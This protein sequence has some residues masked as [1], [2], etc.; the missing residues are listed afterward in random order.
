M[1]KQLAKKILVGILIV[2][3]IILGYETLQLKLENNTLKRAR[4]SSEL[5]SPIV[6]WMDVDEFLAYQKTSSVTFNDLKPLINATITQGTKGK[7]GVY[8]EDL[9]S[10]AWMGINEKEKFI[11]ASLLKVPLMIAILKKVEEGR[12]SLDDELTLQEEDRDMRSGILGMNEPGYK[13]N[14][15]ELLGILTKH[16][17]NTAF[18]MLLKNIS[19]EEYLSARL[20]TGIPLPPADGSETRLSPKEYSNILRSL[21]ISSYLSRPFSELAL[22]IMVDT[23]FES[24][25]PAGLPKGIKISHKVGFYAYG[26]YFH[27]CGIIY[28]PKKPYLLCIMSENNSQEESDRIMENVSRMIYDYMSKKTFNQENH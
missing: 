23:D 10:G 27:D 17:D 24:G 28:L 6:A 13:I 1:D 21:Y 26:A 18:R 5:L 7:Y 3:V 9:T 2:T 4:A 11:P 8:L 20:A 25:I 14:I 12:L 19:D 16:S 22:S 15:K